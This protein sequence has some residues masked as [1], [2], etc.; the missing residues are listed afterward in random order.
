MVVF[1]LSIL[2]LKRYDHILINQGSSAHQTLHPNYST[3]PYWLLLRLTSRAGFCSWGGGRVLSPVGTEGSGRSPFWHFA[4]LLS[5]A[6]TSLLTFSPVPTLCYNA[7]FVMD[8]CRSGYL[9]LPPPPSLVYSLGEEIIPSHHGY[10][11]V[12]LLYISLYVYQALPPC[13]LLE[14]AFGVGIFERGSR[15]RWLDSPLTA[16]LSAVLRWLRQW[17]WCRVH[18][19]SLMHQ[20]LHTASSSLQY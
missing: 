7:L 17:G 6:S 9:P 1:I 13:S 11:L 18:R 2:G 12:L 14:R 15:R 4:G 3:L 5:L 16:P 8:T 20:R 10:C 19:E